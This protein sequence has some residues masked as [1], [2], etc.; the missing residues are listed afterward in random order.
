MN[1]ALVALLPRPR[2]L[3]T[4]C[5]AALHLAALP[6]LPPCLQLSVTRLLRRGVTCMGSW[7][8][9]CIGPALVLRRLA[10]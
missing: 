2:R 8:V 7:C 10:V 5:L 3:P 6:A 4:F 1:G 9:T